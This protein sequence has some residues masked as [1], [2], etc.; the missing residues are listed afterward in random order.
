MKNA[1]S[2]RCIGIFV[3][4]RHERP[5]GSHLGLEIILEGRFSLLC[6]I[7]KANS[8]RQSQLWKRATVPTDFFERSRNDSLG[9]DWPVLLMSDAF[10]NL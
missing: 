7:C 1:C 4:F 10:L 6:M 5:P 2:R 3:P 9:S 8:K